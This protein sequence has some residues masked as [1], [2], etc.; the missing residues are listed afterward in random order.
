MESGLRMCSPFLDSRMIR[1]ANNIALDAHFVPGQPKAVLKKALLKHVPETF[2]NRPKR[3]FGQPIFEWLSPG[4]CLREAAEN[5]ADYPF[6][7]KKVKQD[8]LAKPNW[9]LWT[10]LC[11]DLWHKEFIGYA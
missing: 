11:F 6:V 5:I 2:V 8:I 1:A 7:P 9:I 4:G 3:G 10:L